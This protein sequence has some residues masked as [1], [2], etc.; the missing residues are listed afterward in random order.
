MLNVISDLLGF[1]ERINKSVIV[2]NLSPRVSQLLKYLFLDLP[3]ILLELDV[4]PEQPLLL[5]LV[6]HA[7]APAYH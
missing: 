7:L 3:L 5:I 2:K 1:I 6:S 4:L